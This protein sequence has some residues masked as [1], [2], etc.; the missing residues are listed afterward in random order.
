MVVIRLSPS[1]KKNSPIFKILVTD[2]DSRL[3]GRFIEKIGIYTPPKAASRNNPTRG[4]SIDLKVERFQHWV[5]TGAQPS[6]RLMAL[7]KKLSPGAYA[8]PA[9]ATTTEP[10]KVS[11]T[12]APAKKP[13]AKKTAKKS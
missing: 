6:P 7:V 5:K 10:K 3:T 11:K 2:K 9:A 1:G 13:A 8:V 12:E 4:E